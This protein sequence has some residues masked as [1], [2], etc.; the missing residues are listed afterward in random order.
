MKKTIL[1]MAALIPGVAAADGLGLTAKLGTLGYGAELTGRI[2]DNSNWRL[3]ANG[4]NYSHTTTESNVDYDARLKLQTASLLADYHPFDGT[5][6]VTAGVFY[7]KNRL[8]LTGKPAAGGTYEIDGVT[9]TA[10]QI[11]TLT[12]KL[13]FDKT[14]PYVGIGWGNAVARG[15]GWNFAMD[16]GAI[17]QGKPKFA[18]TADSAFCNADATCRAHLANEQADAEAKLADYKWYPV[19]SIGVSYHF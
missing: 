13:T 15:S 12:G 8:D 4:F 7:N 5:F 1:F 2:T 11:G 16:I 18:L 10:A 9:Y 6:R 3:G 19:I 14:A 17:Y